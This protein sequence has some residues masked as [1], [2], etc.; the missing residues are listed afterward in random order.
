MNTR[1][2]VLAICNF[3]SVLLIIGVNG[4]IGANGFNGNTVAG[5]SIKYNHLFT[6]SPYAFAIW[7]PIFLGLLIYTLNQLVVAFQKS[8]DV[9][10]IERTG[11]WLFLANLFNMLWLFAW[12]IESTFLSV[13]II[14]GALIA[15]LMV[16]LKTNM[17]LAQISISR[18]IVT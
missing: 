13:I 17:G 1:P 16:V 14:V 9:E 2:K 4:Y 12:L 15:L 5:V 7:G 11:W 8:G 18:K 3:I 10:L 6:P